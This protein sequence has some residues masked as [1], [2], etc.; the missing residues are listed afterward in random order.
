MELVIF[1]QDEAENEGIAQFCRGF[2]TTYWRKRTAAKWRSYYFFVTK[3][4]FMKKISIIFSLIISLLFLGEGF[5]QGSAFGIKGGGI[6]GTQTGSGAQSS[7]HLSYHGIAFIESLPAGDS[8]A[9]F[10]QAGYH[11]RGSAR[12]RL[13][14]GNGLTTR[15]FIP[16]AYDF[17][18]LYTS[19]S[20]RDQRGSRMPSS[21]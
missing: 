8:Y 10:A 20:P 2:L 19:P 11:K 3:H 5:A 21:A 6:M 1:R 13:R 7:V 14:F 18:L 9:L 4:D 17:C 12:Q 15:S 16:R